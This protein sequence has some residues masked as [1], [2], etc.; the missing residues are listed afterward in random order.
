MFKMK[1]I[2]GKSV[3]SDSIA[4]RRKSVPSHSV[5]SRR[6]TVSRFRAMRA[7]ASRTLINGLPNSFRALSIHDK[8]LINPEIMASRVQSILRDR[9]ARRAAP[10]ALMYNAVTGQKKRLDMKQA[11]VLGGKRFN[12]MS[13]LSK[14][15]QN[16]EEAYATNRLTMIPGNTLMR[17]RTG[18]IR[19]NLRNKQNE[20]SNACLKKG[21]ND[22]WYWVVFSFNRCQHSVIEEMK[23]RHTEYIISE[24]ELQ[25]SLSWYMSIY[26]LPV[27]I[28]YLSRVALTNAQQ[29]EVHHMKII[30]QHIRNKGVQYN[31]PDA[32]IALRGIKGPLARFTTVDERTIMPCPFPFSTTTDPRVALTFMAWRHLNGN[33]PSTTP[34][35][36]LVIP[37]VPTDPCIYNPNVSALD[38]SEIIL[39]ACTLEIIETQKIPR[40]K[41]GPIPHV[42][43]PYLGQTHSNITAIRRHM[44][45]KDMTNLLY[46]HHCKIQFDRAFGYMEPKWLQQ[47]LNR[48]ANA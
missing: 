36:L 32:F 23:R 42:L 48:I 43:T 47:F 37:L 28:R 2:S 38:E 1:R 15:L 22:D 16:A 27:M 33:A 5:A 3:R 39:P 19:M 18:N 7:A 25:R 6:K 41:L 11:V 13:V 14:A 29:M 34:L 35:H 44:L 20:I 45:N 31:A 30:D 40:E 12:V 17:A 9:R 26:Q 46:I 8:P 24:P 4:S 10:S 21:N